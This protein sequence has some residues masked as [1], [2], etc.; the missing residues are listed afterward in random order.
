MANILSK[1]L[2]LLKLKVLSFLI[3]IKMDKIFKNKSVDTVKEHLFILITQKKIFVGIEL[4]SHFQ[5]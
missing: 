3:L 5:N 2:Q 1:L 4:D